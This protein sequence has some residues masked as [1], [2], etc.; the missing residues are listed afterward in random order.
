[1]KR[2]RLLLALA[3]CGGLP[4]P[5]DPPDAPPAVDAPPPVWATYTI[6]A[7]RHPATITGGGP[8][9]PL[10]AIVMVGGRDYQFAFDTS[11]EYVLTMPVQPDDQLDWNK[12]PGLSDCGTADLS[13]N[14]AMFGW[15][16]RLDLDPRVLEVTAYVNNDSVHVMTPVL[17]ALTD[18]ELAA[19][20]P[21]RYRL[22]L[23]RDRYRFTIFG[24]IGG[25]PIDASGD[26]P[27]VCPTADP[28]AGKWAAGLYFGGT[29][30][31]PSPITG[32]IV[33]QP[34]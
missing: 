27:R 23:D 24:T 7:G 10:R 1:V 34:L 28:L 29:S 9:N 16:W 14:G 13:V 26:L 6:P 21:L 17:L 33:E 19:D 20:Q 2:A 8:D 32:R 15:R 12:L 5:Y 4:E 30:V 3:A 25:R 22:W 31:A 18:A 11:A